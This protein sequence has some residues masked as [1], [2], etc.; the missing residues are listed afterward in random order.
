LIVTPI[1]LV[2]S[3]VRKCTL[4]GNNAA[5]GITFT[6]ES[7]IFGTSE[8]SFHAVLFACHAIKGSAEAVAANAVAIGTIVGAGD[9][10]PAGTIVLIYRETA[11][12]KLGG[13]AY[14]ITGEGNPD[15]AIAEPGEA[16]T[17]AIEIIAIPG[18]CRI[19][20]YA[21]HKQHYSTNK[22]KYTLHNGI[23]FY[24]SM[25]G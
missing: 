5:T 16:G 22:S 19:S 12:A 23:S 18:F 20:R 13:G 10:I 4:V 2:Y 17:V 21:Y 9:E 1:N 14:C 6:F 8:C 24:I 15:V 7:T 11:Y 3:F 25:I